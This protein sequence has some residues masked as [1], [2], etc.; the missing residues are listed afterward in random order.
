MA[1]LF[2]SGFIHGGETI[3]WYAWGF[4]EGEVQTFTPYPMD[5]V[6]GVRLVIQKVRYDRLPVSPP[7]QWRVAFDLVNLDGNAIVYDIW[8]T[9]A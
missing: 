2:A 5:G 3:E 6:P 1:Q 7:W 9:R 4:P 8:W